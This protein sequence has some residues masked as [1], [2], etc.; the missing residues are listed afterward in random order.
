M[1]W[2]VFIGTIISKPKIRLLVYRGLFPLICEPVYI[3]SLPNVHTQ[4]GMC[5]AHLRD[6]RITRKQGSPRESGPSGGVSQ[7]ALLIVASVKLQTRRKGRVLAEVPWDCLA[8]L[9]S[10]SW[11]SRLGVGRSWLISGSC[12][13]MLDFRIAVALGRC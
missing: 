4:K 10:V 12:N 7:P 11:T 13:Q 9:S 6:L 8:P 2:R 1:F 3:K 5:F